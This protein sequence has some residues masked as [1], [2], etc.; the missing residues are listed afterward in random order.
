M[1]SVLFSKKTVSERI[2]KMN[3]YHVFDWE[4]SDE[5]WSRQFEYNSPA[6]SAIELKE[7]S[8][9]ALKS[10]GYKASDAKRYASA[11]IKAGMTSVEKVILHALK[12]AQT[13]K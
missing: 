5:E 12:L 11:G 9:N 1:Q 13:D 6:D 2:E 7:E 8:I 10:L 3:E 4:L